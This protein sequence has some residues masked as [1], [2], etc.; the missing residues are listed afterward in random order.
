MSTRGLYGF[1]KNGQDKTTY[2][3]SD[4]YPD[5]LGEEIVTFCSQNPIETMEKIYD[6]IEMINEDTQPTKE[7]IKW[8]VDA[9]YYNPSVGNQSE[10]DW[11]CLLCGLQGNIE[12]LKRS[13]LNR[14]KVYM[15][16]GSNF[17]KASL[18]CEY[19]YI[20]NLDTLKLEFWVGF[21]HKPQKGNRY[22][23]KPNDDGYYPCRLA[24]AFPLTEITETDRIVD[25]M[26]EIPKEPE[27]DETDNGELP[28]KYIDVLEKLDWRVSGYTNDGGVELEKYSPAGE[29]FTMCVSVKDFPGSVMEYYYDFDVDD[30]IEMWIEARRNGA[31]GVPN[32]RTLVQDAEAIEEMLKTL[33]GALAGI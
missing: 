30:H 6:N 16:D 26:N 29:D 7:Q 12:E 20:I 22:G 11:Y 25:I 13:A 2:N 3:H 1:R 10:N 27:E 9:G 19:A 14:G 23:E 17:I 18:F 32:A 24:A 5:G 8:C 31:S 15:S 28:Q 33:A 21:Q 4:S